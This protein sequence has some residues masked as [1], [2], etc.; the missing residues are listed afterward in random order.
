MEALSSP[1][2]LI[3]AGL[4]AAALVVA[5]RSAQRA[6]A[7]DA[8]PNTGEIVWSLVAVIVLV[9]VTVAVHLG[10]GRGI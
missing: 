8:A 1:E 6:T 10:G 7:T 4:T 5:L 3:Q 2:M 9:G